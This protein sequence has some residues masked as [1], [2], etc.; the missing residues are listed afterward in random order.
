MSSVPEKDC[1]I[2]SGLREK[3]LNSA[4]DTI[5]RRIEQIS[6]A[7]KEREHQAYLELWQEIKKQDDAIAEMFDDLKRSNAVFKMA[8]LK[9]YGVLTVEQM[10]L[11]STE[12]QEQVARLCEFR[13]E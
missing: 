1:K 7:R 9:H 11:F 13:R 3:L 10:A 12:T 4:C 5:F 8:A 6:S 2:L